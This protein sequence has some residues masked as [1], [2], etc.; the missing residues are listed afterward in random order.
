MLLT[1]GHDTLPF[2]IGCPRHATGRDRIPVY[3]AFIIRTPRAAISSTGTAGLSCAA[4]RRAC[5]ILLQN[6]WSCH[7]PYRTPFSPNSGP[8]ECAGSNFARDGCSGHR[9][10]ERGIRG[11]GQG[12]SR[13]HEGDFS[14]VRPRD[15]V[16]RFRDRGLGSGARK[17]PFSRR[18]S[19]VVRDRTFFIPLAR[20]RREIRHQ[21]D[22]VPGN[23]RRGASAAE[24]E[25]RLAADHGHAIKAVMV[26]HNETSTG[27]TSRIPEL[28]RAIDAAHH[29]ALFWWTPFLPS[30]RSTIAMTS[31]EW[32]SP[33]PVRKKA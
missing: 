17:Y 23:W 8:H 27:V 12:S 30:L 28:R 5:T 10:P 7:D 33:L 19:F 24:L 1:H 2:P 16:S 9:P 32:T 6:Q 22:Y 25:S 15:H 21:V 29:P 18:S 31:G 14:N 20:N 4:P 3:K 13:G 11:P 26:V